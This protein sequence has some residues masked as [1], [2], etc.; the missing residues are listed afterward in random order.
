MAEDDDRFL[1]LAFDL[2]WKSRERGDHPFGAVLVDDQG[3]ILLEVENS[4]VT[5]RDCTAHAELNLMRH[6]TQNY[7][8]EVLARC[9]LYSST[10]PCPMCAAAI[11][12]GR[13]GRLVYGLSQ[14]GLYEIVGDQTDDVLYLPC[15]EVLARG[16]RVVEVVGPLLEDEA[17]AVHAGYWP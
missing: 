11:F 2:A 9:T 7:A 13:V 3:T 16:R 12:W 1:R 8:P 5:G 6:A 14:E 15:R 17:R 10:E 4:A